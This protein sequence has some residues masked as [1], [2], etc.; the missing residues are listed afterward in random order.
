MLIQ[1]RDNRRFPWLERLP[2]PPLQ[3]QLHWIRDGYKFPKCRRLCPLVRV[4]GRLYFSLSFLHPAG[5]AA[6]VGLGGAVF[7]TVRGALA[8]T[9]SGSPKSIF[10][11]VTKPTHHHCDNTFH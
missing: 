3:L 1:L 10:L 9:P 2:L 8:F 4:G 5:G 7:T 6:R 11:T